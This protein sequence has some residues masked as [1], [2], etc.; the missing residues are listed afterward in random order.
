MCGVNGVFAY[1]GA[2]PSPSERE[3]LA[4]RDAMAA[5][6]PDGAG[7]WWSEDRR[8]GFG[9]RRLAILDPTDRA[10]QPMLSADGRYAITYNGEIYNF[11]E[12][13]AGLEAEGVQFRTTSDTEAL[14]HLY[15]KRGP[16][17][18]RELRGMFALAIWDQARRGVFLARDPYGIKPL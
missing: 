15:A 4:V 12:L 3:L 7:V 10:A 9:H 2:A 13:K 16:D 17:M 1:A 5:R 8:C 18:V 6:G 14:L 11:P